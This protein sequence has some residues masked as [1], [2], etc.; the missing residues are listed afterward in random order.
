MARRVLVVDDNRALART[1]GELLVEAGAEAR[2]FESSHRALE[3]ARCHPIDA[4]LVDLDMPELDGAQLLD[5]IRRVSP[6]ARRFLMTGSIDDARISALA[7]RGIASVFRKPFSPSRVIDIL[8]PRARPVDVGPAR[9][10]AAMSRDLT[11][12]VPEDDVAE[13]ARLMCE[14][15]RGFLVVLDPHGR[16]AGALT[17]RDACMAAY[18]R[19][20]PLYEISVAAVMSRGVRTCSPDDT[21][22]H[23]ARTMRDAQVR[24]L[25]VV[26]AGG[27]VVGVLSLTDLVRAGEHL[28][29][30]TMRTLRS[31]VAGRV[32]AEPRVA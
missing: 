11:A 32:R 29:A 30:T 12:C 31:I 4:A 6:E 14:H 24:R 19:G 1:L 10:A 15:D 25:P 27:R 8:V 21:L 26:E 7:T 17:D 2:V 18:M 16:L 13:A 5:E 3:Y 9:V 28:D 20:R 23:A 22:E